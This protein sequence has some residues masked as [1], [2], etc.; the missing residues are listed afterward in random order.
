MERKQAIVIGVDAKGEFVWGT[1][2]MPRWQM[3][4][5][6]VKYVGD[7]Y[8]FWAKL[9]F[10]EMT[11]IEMDSVNM[12]ISQRRSYGKKKARRSTGD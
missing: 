4:M 7:F 5:F 1:I 6:P 3:R 10:F 8:A 12:D 11:G 2:P 9:H